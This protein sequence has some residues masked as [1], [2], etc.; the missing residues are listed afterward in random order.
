[1]GKPWEYKRNFGEKFSYF[2]TDTNGHNLKCFGETTSKYIEWDAS[3]DTLNVVGTLALTGTVGL[4]GDLTVVGTSDLGT[5]AE[6][7]AYTVGGVAGIDFSGAVTT[8]T[9]VK[10]IVTAAA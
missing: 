8:V 10:G 1:M 2:G 5:S 3:A 4:T 9:V 7:D 6:A